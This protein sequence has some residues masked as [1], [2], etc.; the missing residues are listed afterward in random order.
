MFTLP[1]RYFSRW[2]SLLVFLLATN[3]SAAAGL[4][5]NFTAVYELKK[6]GITIG[7]TKRT[8]RRE[9]DHYVF[10]SITRPKGIAKLFT[11]GKVIERSSWRFYQQKPRPLTYTFSNSGSKKNRNVKLAFNWAENTVINSITGKP[12][13]MLLESGTQD[14]LLYQLRLMLDLP[15]RKPTL[16]YPI[17]DGGKLKYYD[18]EIVGKEQIRTKLGSF[19]TI[20]LRRIK[21][22]R[23]T[24][25]WCAEQLA[26]LPVR[27]EQQ[28][29][30]DSPV[31]AALTS[32]KGFEAR[33]EGRKPQE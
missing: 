7:E 28:K 25:L 20:R 2:F 16:R 14:K 1:P 19:D 13:N 22:S 30:D 10:E 23:T 21:G 15:T 6:S 27:I 24:T 8:L 3:A 18:I 26:Y 29:N 32:V 17:A 12:W 5:D 9:T 31:V 33:V 11:S 4:P